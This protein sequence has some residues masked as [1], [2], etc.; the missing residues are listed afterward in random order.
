MK[1]TRSSHDQADTRLAGQV[2]VRAC[3]VAGGLFVAKANEAN[4]EIDGLLRDLDDR[5]AD[6]PK[7]VSDAKIAERLGDD[8]SP[9]H[10]RH[11]ELETPKA[12]SERN[13]LG[14]GASLVAASTIV[15][16][17]RLT[18]PYDLVG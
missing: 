14:T 6:N 10:F 9:G 13:V 12:G 8:T 7:D 18:K 15:C 2:S 17:E 16:Y 11:L 1:D 3:R 5:D 4:A